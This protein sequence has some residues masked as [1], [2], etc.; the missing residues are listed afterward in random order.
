MP[1]APPSTSTARPI[2][3]E[4]E[5][6]LS[7]AEALELANGVLVASGATAE[8]AAAVADSIVAAE[9]Q[10]LSEVGFDYLPVYCRHLEI[11]RVDG[12]ARPTWRRTAPAAVIADAASGFSQPAFLAGLDQLADAA[13]ANGIAALTIINSYP[14]G[15]LG[16]FVERLARQGLMGLAFANAG[17]AVAPWGSRV[18]LFGTNPLAFAA[19][20]HTADPLVIDLATSAVARVKVKAAAEAGRPIPADWAFD[21]DGRP[22]TDATAALAGSLAPLGG[23]KGY[24]LA[25]MVEMLAAGL[26][27][28]NWSHEAPAAGSDTAR[29]PRLGQ[30]II[31]I[32]PKHFGGAGLAE[33]FDGLAHE[34]EQAGA[35]QPGARRH[36]AQAE[37][38][39]NGL[40][41]TPAIRRLM[42]CGASSW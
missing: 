27:G 15:M 30:T 41:V 37:A 13:T 20:R 33:R 4:L 3:T 22:T 38:R 12:R 14:A 35:R 21:C 7:I 18:P 40:R 25:V 19:P 17:A 1:P 34:I 28:M 24:A 39:R 31:A 9:A 6:R 10:G 42:K 11:G 16:W 29:R 23:P 8:N 32:A 5:A 36:Q 2:S 26:T